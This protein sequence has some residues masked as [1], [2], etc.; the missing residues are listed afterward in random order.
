[1]QEVRAVSNYWKQV[2]V[3]SSISSLNSVY[4]LRYLI[5]P[6][7]SLEEVPVFGKVQL[8]SGWTSHIFHSD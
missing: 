6:P 3:I 5:V 8:K 1:M 4:S 2:T 7:A